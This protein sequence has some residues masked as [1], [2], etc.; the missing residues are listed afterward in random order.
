MNNTSYPDPRSC[1]CPALPSLPTPSL[2]LGNKEPEIFYLNIH[3][4]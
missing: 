3:Q 4:K 1:V 2:G